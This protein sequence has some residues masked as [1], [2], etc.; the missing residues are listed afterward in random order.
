LRI[1]AADVVSARWLTW[2]NSGLQGAVGIVTTSIG[3]NT[4]I[5]TTF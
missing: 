5:A 2:A 1:A 3:L 4:V